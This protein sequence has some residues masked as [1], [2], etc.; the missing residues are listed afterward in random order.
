MKPPITA[1]SF[2]LLKNFE[3]CPYRVYL[4]NV[5]KSPQP[6]VND[7]DH[8]LIRGDRLH[9]EAEAFIKGT[10]PLTRG[11]RRFKAR[12]EE[13]AEKYPEGT[14]ECEQRWGFDKEW[15]EVDFFSDDCW[16]R[17]ICDVVEHHPNLTLEVGD[18]KSGKSF[19][20][21]VKHMQQQQLYGLTAMMRYPEVTHV[22]TTMDYLD[23]GKTKASKYTRDVLPQ[24]LGRWEQRARK[25]TEALVFPAKPNRGNCKFCPYGVNV[26][27]GACPYAVES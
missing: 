14:I 10:G 25:L 24:L 19:G 22:K 26:G 6:P 4:A 11:L 8:P 23:E 2:S 5:E 20:N 21:E 16:A 3:A 27:T 9:K 13:L 12:L 7:P 1:W 18:W 17:V 15:N